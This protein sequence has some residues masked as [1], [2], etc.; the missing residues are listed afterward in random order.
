M[1][2]TAPQA[3]LPDLFEARAERCSRAAALMYEDVALSYAEVNARANR[4]ARLLVARGV[5]PER[6]VACAFP[7]SVE[8]YVALLAVMKAGG[9]YLPVDPDYPPQR[10]AYMLT[11]ADPVLVLTTSDVASRI[12]ANSVPVLP[13]DDAGV[14]AECE[15][16][17]STDVTDAERGG[18]LSPSNAAYVIYTS[19]STGRP[20]GVVVSH[21]GISALAAS[22]IERFGV[23]ES[24]RVLQFASPSFDASIS[25]V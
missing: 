3:V 14:I 12:D 5:G 1:T 20:K 23:R 8:L 10:I 25:E 13:V 4:L 16:F 15:G 18:F 24:S 21:A 11:D 9:V 22:Q 2:R 7:R 19:G 17:A 6:V